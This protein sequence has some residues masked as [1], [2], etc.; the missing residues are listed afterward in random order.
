MR[1]ALSWHC[2]KLFKLFEVVRICQGSESLP[3]IASESWPFRRKGAKGE[4]VHYDRESVRPGSGAPHG[5]FS[6]LSESYPAAFAQVGN[7]GKQLFDFDSV[8]EAK[9]IEE[10]F[11]Q[12]AHF[13]RHPGCLAWAC[14]NLNASDG[15][16][17]HLGLADYR[18]SDIPSEVK[19]IGFAD[20]EGAQVESSRWFFFDGYPDWQNLFGAVA[21]RQPI[22]E[23][24]Y[25]G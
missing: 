9:P 14:I 18:S 19:Q 11:L 10:I 17:E 6:D 13:H 23:R 4:A 12:V 22:S 16:S 21:M 2:T 1:Q 3:T 15:R 20:G 8:S 25:P 7:A 24:Y 5:P